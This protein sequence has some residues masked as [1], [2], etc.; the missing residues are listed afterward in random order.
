MRST[1]SLC[2]S[3]FL[4]LPL[5]RWDWLRYRPDHAE[6]GLNDRP[7]AFLS[8][9]CR[10]QLCAFWK[11]VMTSVGVIWAVRVFV[12]ISERLCNVSRETGIF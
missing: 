3:D 1:D 2:I 8:K 12:G 10:F 4:L 9:Q 6:G 11:L 7:W 5:L